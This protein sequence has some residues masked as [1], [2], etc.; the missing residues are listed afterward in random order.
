MEKLDRL[1][2]AATQLKSGK[3]TE[4]TTCGSRKS[5]KMEILFVSLYPGACVIVVVRTSDD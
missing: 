3:R 5:K 2:A 4:E 1:A